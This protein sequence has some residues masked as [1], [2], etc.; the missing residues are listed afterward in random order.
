[1]NLHFGLTNLPATLFRYLRMRFEGM[2]LHFGLTNTPTKFAPCL[3]RMPDFEGFWSSYRPSSA[4]TSFTQS[5]T[6]SWQ[7]RSD[8]RV[9]ADREMAGE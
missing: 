7:N 6:V 8:L 9:S 2:N 3:K 1:V 5:N 4:E